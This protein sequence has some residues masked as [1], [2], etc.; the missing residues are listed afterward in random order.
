MPKKYKAKLSRKILKEKYPL[1]LNGQEELT[2][3]V[4]RLFLSFG[5]FIVI[6]LGVDL[7]HFTH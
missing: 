6:A 2:Q 4:G 3:F 5:I 1:K 7:Y